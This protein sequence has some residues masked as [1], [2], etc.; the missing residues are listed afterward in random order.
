MVFLFVCF[1]MAAVSWPDKTGNYIPLF[2][3]TKAIKDSGWLVSVTHVHRAW[4]KDDYRLYTMQLLVIPGKCAQILWRN[5]PISGVTP[6]RILSWSYWN[7]LSH[8]MGKSY[9]S[10]GRCQDEQEKRHSPHGLRYDG[11]QK[12]FSIF[13]S[14]KPV[15]SALLSFPLLWI[16]IPF[17]E[18]NGILLIHLS[19]LHFPYFKSRIYPPL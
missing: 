17:L 5:A 13:Q 11:R 2:L 1:P 6:G 7:E 18:T 15:H 19:K 10:I 16:K 9:L 4:C 8:Q 14:C 12:S 3:M